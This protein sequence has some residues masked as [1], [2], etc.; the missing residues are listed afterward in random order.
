MKIPPSLKAP[1]NV[2]RDIL[3]ISHADR[4]F[5]IDDGED[6]GMSLMEIPD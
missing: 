4:L 1:P 3:A 5:D 2:V 6:E